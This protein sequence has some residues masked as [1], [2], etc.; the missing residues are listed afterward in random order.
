M[1]VEEQ[2]TSS[3]SDKQEQNVKDLRVLHV[4]C[5]CSQCKQKEVV[6]EK[7][8]T[9]LAV[10]RSG[11]QYQQD[12][13]IEDRVIKDPKVWEEQKKVRMGCL[14][15]IQK[16][17]KDVILTQESVPLPIPSQKKQGI[18]RQ[19]QENQ[20]ENK[21]PLLLT[22][23]MISLDQILSLVPKFKKQILHKLAQK[24]GV[25]HK[26]EICNVQLENVDYRGC[27]KYMFNI[28]KKK[29][30]EHWWMEVLESTSYQNSCTRS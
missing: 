5:D 28:S 16:Q 23:T 15:E 12:K 19:E 1:L 2:D 14:R 22:K 21:E 9:V 20:G 3:S 27:Q 6:L 7:P 25:D 13:D 30:Q 18:I 29:L 8:V 24:D 17:Q 11:K 26:P 4:Q 10:T